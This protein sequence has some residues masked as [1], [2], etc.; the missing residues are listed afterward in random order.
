MGTLGEVTD[1]KELCISLL[2]R[3]TPTGRKSKKI[4][5]MHVEALSKVTHRAGH[6]EIR[7]GIT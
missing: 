6:L 4:V 2:R 3:R 5:K 1:Y 7:K